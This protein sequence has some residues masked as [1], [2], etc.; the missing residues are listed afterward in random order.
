M[1]TAAPARSLGLWRLMGVMYMMVCCGAYATE[2]MVRAGGGPLVPLAML[3]VLPWVWGLPSALGVAEL[4]TTIPSNAGALMWVNVAWNAPLTATLC[5]CT[6]VRNSIDSAIYPNL[7]CDYLRNLEIEGLPDT[8]Y[9]WAAM[10]AGVVFLASLLNAVGIDAVGSFSLLFMAVCSAPFAILFAVGAPRMDPQKWLTV[11]KLDIISLVPVMTWN[12][13]GFDES[14]HM[15]EEVKNY[16]IFSRAV[17]GC[18]FLTVA[19]YILPILVGTSVKTDYENWTAGYW[20]KISD[21][22]AGPW[23]KIFMSVGGCFSALGLMSSY[24]CARSRA[25]SSMGSMEVL[26]GPLSEWLSHLNRRF[27]TPVR[28]IVV[29]GIITLGFALWLDFSALVK[30]V[31]VIYSCRVMCGLSSLVRMRFRYPRLTRPYRLPFGKWG[32]L[33]IM[34]IPIGF[35]AGNIGLGVAS[36]MRTRI[37]GPGVIIISALIGY[38]YVRFGKPEGFRGC[39]HSDEDAEYFDRL[40]YKEAEPVDIINGIPGFARLHYD[41]IEPIN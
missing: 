28:A 2:E 31:A 20:V 34:I 38:V 30:V 39:I 27:A 22:V 8:W 4:S 32:T 17:C 24:T 29:N 26:P 3:V 9:F 36:D 12:L 1:T 18:L 16:A 40:G 10:K 41:D 19:T 35:L 21:E 37:M 25:L 13:S 7:F 5:L 23:L 14:G 6:I 33:C 11:E 15:V